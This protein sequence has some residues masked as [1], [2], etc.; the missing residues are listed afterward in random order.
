[1]LGKRASP[2]RREAVRKGPLWHLAGGPPYRTPGSE[3]GC[4]GKPA[5]TPNEGTHRAADPTRSR[6]ARMQARPT[7]RASARW[8]RQSRPSTT[9]NNCTVTPLTFLEP[10]SFQV[11]AL[12]TVNGNATDQMCEDW[13]IDGQGRPTAVDIQATALG[14]SS[15]LSQSAA[16]S[17]AGDVVNPVHRRHEF[18]TTRTPGRACLHRGGIRTKGATRPSPVILPVLGCLGAGL[19]CLGASLGRLGAAPQVVEGDGETTGAAIDTTSAT[20]SVVSQAAPPA[21][22]AL[23]S[24]AILLDPPSTVSRGCY[25]RFLPFTLVTGARRIADR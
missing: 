19:S 17:L 8:P 3:G 2:V 20:W 6:S 16:C 1:M 13:I 11:T 23:A 9:S 5:F 10:G 25:S 14:S 21:P 4:A 12:D 18:V 15:G 22:C 7:W 24:T